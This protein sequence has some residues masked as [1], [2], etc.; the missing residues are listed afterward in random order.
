LTLGS[1][2]P[3]TILA[4]NYCASASLAFMNSSI[5]T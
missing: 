2:I 3:S 1:L 5:D 4:A